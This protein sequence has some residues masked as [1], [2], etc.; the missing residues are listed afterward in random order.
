MNINNSNLKYKIRY[1]ANRWFFSTNSK[2]IGTL[3]LILGLLLGLIFAVFCIYIYCITHPQDFIIF[4]ICAPKNYPD[5]FSVVDSFTYVLYNKSLHH[6]V[7]SLMHYYCAVF[8]LI[9][10]GILIFYLFLLV[11]FI[12]PKSQA[13]LIVLKI[14]LISI[15]IIF[16]YVIYLFFF[17][18]WKI[19]DVI[20][21]T[22]HNSSLK[23]EL[24]DVIFNL[25]NPSNP[26]VQF[27]LFDE[28]INQS[29]YQNVNTSS[30][31]SL[32]VCGQLHVT[33]YLSPNEVIDSYM[34]SWYLKLVSDITTQFFNVKFV[35]NDDRF[36]QA[37]QV[38]IEI[39]RNKRKNAVA[40]ASSDDKGSFWGIVR[41][42]LWFFVISAF[43]HGKRRRPFRSD[44]AVWPTWNPFNDPDDDIE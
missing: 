1:F 37:V 38:F 42:Y 2:N 13:D 9:V 29:V 11:F 16:F 24:R 44:S 23:V 33:V 10:W 18:V 14:L 15:I 36:W 21:T 4:L 40:P 39:E 5:L 6:E 34:S 8:M 43:I 20:K 28:E 25:I 12:N 7:L 41:M 19:G 30:E 35:L 32:P 27:M 31:I 22:A 17:D 3:D 26:S